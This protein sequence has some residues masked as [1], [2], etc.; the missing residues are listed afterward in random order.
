MLDGHGRA[1]RFIEKRYAIARCKHEMVGWYV[2]SEGLHGQF[3]DKFE[4][5]PPPI[6]KSYYHHVEETL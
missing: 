4:D 1:S 3:Y 2:T 5:I 6:F